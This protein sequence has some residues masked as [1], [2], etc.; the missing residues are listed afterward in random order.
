MQFRHTVGPARPVVNIGVSCATNG[1]ARKVTQALRAWGHARRS[2]KWRELS[3]VR[4]Q[5]R[6]VR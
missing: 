1:P 6:K 4:L 3:G 5:A 2:T